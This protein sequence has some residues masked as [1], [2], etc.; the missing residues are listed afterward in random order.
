MDTIVRLS[1]PEGY[2]Q[3]EGARLRYQLA[4]SGEQRKLTKVI[5]K[6]G[7]TYQ[8]ATEEP[9]RTAT[10]R[11]RQTPQAVRVS[12]ALHPET[13]VQQV[14]DAF[15]TGD[16]EHFLGSGERGNGV[17]LRGQILQIKVAEP[18]TYAAVPFFA[19]S[20]GWGV[21]LDTE[22]VAAFAFPG[23]DGGTGCQLGDHP[24]C[25]FPPLEDRAE[26]CVTGARLDEDLYVGSFPQTLKAYERDAG[27]VRIPPPSELELIK[28]RDVNEGP[29]EV[30]SDLKRMQAAKKVRFE[31][32]KGSG[33][34]PV[35]EFEVGGFSPASYAS[36]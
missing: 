22:R 4:V 5:S 29:D 34:I 24:A 9:D 2:T 15:E 17:D 8:V 26:V 30:I 12:V 14:Y 7:D 35:L 21:R 18:C 36:P 16:D 31:L 13:G 1:R 27:G 11:V 6:Q 32:P 25:G 23:T 3:D 19:G 33:R 20:A 28:W 10:V